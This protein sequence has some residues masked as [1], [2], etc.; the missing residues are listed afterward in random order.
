M[1][2]AL[3]SDVHGNL[4]A[5]QAVAADIAA[6]RPDVSVVAVAVAASMIRRPVV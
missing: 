6:W 3:L 5:L 2:F 1:K 4:P